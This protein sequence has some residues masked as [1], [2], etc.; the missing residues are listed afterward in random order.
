MTLCEVFTSVLYVVFLLRVGGVLETLWYIILF[1]L[2]LESLIAVE[3]PSTKLYIV[4]DIVMLRDV[5][6][7]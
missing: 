7:F 2:I 5:G 3:F 1:R 4:F 6:E